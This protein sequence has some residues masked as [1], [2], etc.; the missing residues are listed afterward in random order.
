MLQ[1][2]KGHLPGVLITSGAGTPNSVGQIHIRGI[3]SIN[4]SSEPLIVV[5][6]IPSQISLSGLDP[7]DIKSVTVLKD[8]AATS[9]YG[10]RASNG[11]IVVTTKQGKKG[12]TNFNFSTQQ[13]FNTFTINDRNKPLG[14]R[15]M[16]ELLKEGWV[17]AGH[18][19]SSFAAKVRSEGI[20]PSINN[21]WLNVITQTG[22]FHKYH[23]S[24][25]GG[26]NKTNFYAAAGYT[27]STSPLKNTDY[28]RAN[29]ML[30]IHSQTSKRLDLS[31]K[32][33]GYYDLSHTQPDA[34][35]FANP[36]RALFRL[37][38]WLP[39]GGR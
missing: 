4:A 35:S 36:V 6:G 34:G 2:V 37:Q 7:D 25:S 20:D 24:A 15:E 22:H 10:S 26:S 17:N 9:I 1:S 5:D 29:V 12:E 21:N 19:A 14:T 23:L 16:L 30:S 38:S 28:K 3:G 18:S 27:K 33:L 11:V 31:T 39:C 32:I 13:G 8:A